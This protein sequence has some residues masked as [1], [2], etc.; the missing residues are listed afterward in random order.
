[1]SKRSIETVYYFC[2][3]SMQMIRNDAN[4][5]HFVLYQITPIKMGRVTTGLSFTRSHEWPTPILYLVFLTPTFK[6][7]RSPHFST[8][9]YLN[10]MLKPTNKRR[11][12]PVSEM[13]TRCKELWRTPDRGVY[14]RGLKRGRFPSVP[15]AP[16]SRK[17]VVPLGSPRR[18]GTSV[19]HFTSTRR[20]PLQK[21]SAAKPRL[22]GITSPRR[23]PQLAQSLRGGADALLFLSRT[24]LFHLLVTGSRV[25]LCF[26][27]EPVS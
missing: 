18:A 2:T 17:H 7:L 14:K 12:Q 26:A 4:N 5:K 13:P 24:L 1:M 27:V 6:A 23:A 10:N 8:R 25:V 3:F 19:R 11:K 22:S 21:R 9:A 15:R 20:V 16:R